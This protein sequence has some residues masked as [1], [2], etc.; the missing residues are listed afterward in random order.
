MTS[1]ASSIVM[2]KTF[3][4]VFFV[5]SW[6]NEWTYSEYPGKE[7]GKFVRSAGSFFYDAEA[8]KGIQTSQDY[9][10]YAL[11]RKFS[12]FTNE[13]KDLIVQF[14]VK[15]EQDI[16]CGGG[17]IK[18]FNC[19]LEPEKLHGETPYEIMFGNNEYLFQSIF[20]STYHF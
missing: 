13:R 5:D 19:D 17:Y 9:R 6:E 20:Y 1:C 10:F 7:Y 2:F 11:S 3:R 8:D 16:D 14:T 18:L 12:P 4:T 15:H